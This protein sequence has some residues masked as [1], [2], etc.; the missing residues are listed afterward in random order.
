MA[1]YT[2]AS[3]DDMETFYKGLFR[4]ARATLGVRSFGL[5]VVELAPHADNHPLHDHPGDQEEVF[6]V[7]RGTGELVVDGE[8]VPL[9]PESIVRG[10]HRAPQLLKDQPGGLVARESQL[11]LEQ[12]GAS[13]VHDGA[14]GDR[15]LLVAAGTLPQVAPREHPRL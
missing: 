9:A 6:V 12:R 10:D 5:A 15:R 2:A 14:C 1:D 11:T 7:L 8:N 4:K 3:I 13:G